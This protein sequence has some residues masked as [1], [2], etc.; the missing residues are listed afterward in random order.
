MNFEQVLKEIIGENNLYFPKNR[1][2]ALRK[3]IYWLYNYVIEENL[4]LDQDQ[5][6]GVI[7]KFIQ[8]LHEY[9]LFDGMDYYEIRSLLK[10]HH[11]TQ[12]T[13]FYHTKDY[14]KIEGD[15]DFFMYLSRFFYSVAQETELQ[16]KIDDTQ[17]SD[18]PMEVYFRTENGWNSSQDDQEDDFEDDEP[19][20]PPRTISI[21][22]VIGI[23]FLFWVP[24]FS[25]LR[26][27]KIYLINGFHKL[28]E[29]FKG[30]VDILK[31]VSEDYANVW[32]FEIIDDS[33]TGVTIAVDLYDDEIMFIEPEHLQQIKTEKDR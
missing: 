27:G 30:K 22:N 16:K 6:I 14:I 10:E 11:F 18:K 19:E 31:T 25:R 20:L 15:R 9:G 24:E 32:V 21:E 2:V 1:Q 12:E 13:H 7:R 28:N 5:I 29:E 33:D 26:V 8:T 17:P 23:Q 4:F 3:S